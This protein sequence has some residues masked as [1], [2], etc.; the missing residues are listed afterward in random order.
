MLYDGVR[1]KFEQN[2]ALQDELLSTDG[3]HLYEATTDSYFGCG[4]GYDSKRWQQK[5][6][7]G[8]NIAGLVLKKVRDELLGVFPEE[9]DS[10]NTLIEIASQEEA[11]LIEEMESSSCHDD[12]S[13]VLP[14][15]NNKISSNRTDLPVSGSNRQDSATETE[16]KYS[17]HQNRYQAPSYGQSQ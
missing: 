4:I 10:N 9:G 15:H 3:K 12:T 11:S 2:L 16:G 8:E 7:S 6:W 13:G 5:D 17:D 14:Q 1:A